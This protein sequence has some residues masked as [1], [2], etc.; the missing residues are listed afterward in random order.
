MNIRLTIITLLIY[1]SIAMVIFFTIKGTITNTVQAA[2][3]PREL[4]VNDVLYYSDSSQHT[5]S[6]LW[7][8]GNGNQT[9]R[10]KGY[11]QFRKAGRYLIK[12]TI[13]NQL[14]DTFL[15]N[16]K[17]PKLQYVKDTAITIYASPTGITGQNVHFKILGADVE[18]AEWYFGESGKIDDRQAETFHSYSTPGKYEVKLVTNLNQNAP[19]FHTITISPAYKLADNILTQEND[20]AGG[21]G[22]GGGSDLKQYI[23]K[24][25]SGVSFSNNY[26]YIIKKFLCENTHVTVTTN[27]RGGNDFY[28]YCQNLQLN[29]GVIIDNVATESDPRTGCINKLVITQH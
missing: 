26:N 15:V 1:T 7:E 6:R 25:A 19:I 21:G 22:G 28:S 10:S 24:I 2:V 12:L 27:G 13:N 18:W 4:T 8:F 14:A 29:S 11:Y 9:S 5:T 23:Q 20:P 17:A 16:V 3:F